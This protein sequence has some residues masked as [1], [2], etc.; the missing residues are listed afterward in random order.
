MAEKSIYIPSFTKI[1]TLATA[2]FLFIL[3][4]ALSVFEFL[5]CQECTFYCAPRNKRSIPLPESTDILIQQHNHQKDL[6]PCL[7]LYYYGKAI[8]ELEKNTKK[9]F[10]CFYGACNLTKSTLK[11]FIFVFDFN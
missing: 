7:S 11:F 3:V 9:E 5:W 1:L 8:D 10:N 6:N 4:D 2:P